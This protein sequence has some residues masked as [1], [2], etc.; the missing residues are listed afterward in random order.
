[1][2]YAA[3]V[4]NAQCL[5]N[6]IV[7]DAKDEPITI[8]QIGTIGN[9]YT[10]QGESIHKLGEG[11]ESSVKYLDFSVGVNEEAFADHRALINNC[12]SLFADQRQFEH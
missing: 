3:D 9:F 1:M 7:Y 5:L 2:I 11:V 4:K 8:S 10:K 12:L 6:E